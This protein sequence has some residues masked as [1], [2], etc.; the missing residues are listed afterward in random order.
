M[1][2][3]S[4]RTHLAMLNNHKINNGVSMDNNIL[5]LIA[6]LVF[7]HHIFLLRWIRSDSEVGSFEATAA[8]LPRY[9]AAQFTMLK[10]A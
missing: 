8:N 2:D 4:E 5:Q 1:F 10:S 3:I 6:M 7:H 9:P